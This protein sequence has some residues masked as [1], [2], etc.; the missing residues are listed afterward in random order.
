MMAALL[1]RVRREGLLNIVG[2]CCG[3]TPGPHPRDRRGDQ[4][5]NRAAFVPIPQ[6]DPA[7]HRLSG[8]EPLVDRRPEPTS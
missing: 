7:M 8:L 5:R 3:T 2:G 1:E 4:G 6:R